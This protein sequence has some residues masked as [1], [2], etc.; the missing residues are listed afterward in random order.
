MTIIIKNRFR[1]VSR[2]CNI[3]NF[4]NHRA[5]ENPNSLLSVPTRPALW[6]G[7]SLPYISIWTFGYVLKK[8]Q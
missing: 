4:R 5:R 6:D 3:C 1:F 8:G 7:V 2:I